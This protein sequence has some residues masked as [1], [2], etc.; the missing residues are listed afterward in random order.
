M[1][2]G[3]LKGKKVLIVDDEP[4]VLETL[5]EL[6]SDCNLRKASSFEAAKELLEK[7]HFDIAVLDIM[8]VD[9]YKLLEIAKGK[10]VIPVMLTAHALSI[11]NTIQSYKRGAALYVPKDKMT[12]ITDYLEE[13]LHA[14]KAGKSTWWRW[15][16]HFE[17][18]YE[19]KFESDWKNKDQAFWKSFPYT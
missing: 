16:E 1:E 11:E 2:K 13:V 5:E 18:Y 8:G 15:L 12:N 3:L 7:E 14:I 4:D 10:K 6:L 19:K 9:G 17:S